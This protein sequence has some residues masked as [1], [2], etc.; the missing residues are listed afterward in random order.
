MT[1]GGE[2]SAGAADKAKEELREYLAI[3]LYLCVFLAALLNYR[4][5]VLAEVG[6]TYA[7]W[8]YAAIE[9]LILGKV[10][11][12]GEAMRFGKRLEHRPLIVSAAY[13]SLVFGCFVLAFL[14][15]EHAVHALLTHESL[16]PA[17]ERV[18]AQPS[19]AIAHVLLVIVAFIPYFMV[20]EAGRL[21]GEKS[22]LA[23]M[24]MRPGEMG[25][26]RGPGDQAS[27]RTM[28]RD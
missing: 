23:L 25:S 4:R 20:R 18:F 10:I 14:V 19:A 8:G 6:I 5:V 16:A 22:L 15:L 2:K 13:K 28:A 17:V 27:A 1:T 9:A 11:L 26:A 7:H 3:S 24:L 21:L 12:L